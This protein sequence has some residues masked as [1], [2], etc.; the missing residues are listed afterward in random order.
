MK[1]QKFIYL[2]LTFIMVSVFLSSTIF[3][4]TTVITYGTITEHGSNLPWRLYDD[5]TLVVEGGSIN[6]SRDSAIPQAPQGTPFPFTGVRRII[7]TGSVTAGTSLSGLFS[8]F[9]YVTSIDGLEHFDTSNVTDMSRMFQGISNIE[10]LD[11][12]SWDV[13][14]VQYM[15]T[16]FTNARGLIS[17]DLSGWDNRNVNNVGFFWASDL[18][19]LALGEHFSFGNG[20]LPD[21]PNND[22]FVGRW[23]NVGSGTPDNPQGEFVFTSDE[24][25][26]YYDGAIHADT[27]VWQPRSSVEIPTESC[28]SVRIYG[29]ITEFGSNL[30]W[31]LCECGTM[32]VD[33]GYINWHGVWTMRDGPS[34]SGGYVYIDQSP[35]SEYSP[36]IHRIV[37]TGQITA[38]VSLRSL[39]FQLGNVVVIDGLEHFDTSNV[40]D[41]RSVFSGLGR[42][43]SLDG[44]SAWNVGN[45][46]E[47][48]HMFSGMSSL[49]ALDLS[50]WDTGNARSMV[51]MFSMPWGGTTALRE[52]N[53]SGWDTRNVRSMSAMF[54]DTSLLAR[55]DISGWNLENLS[56]TEQ[57]FV[58][59]SFDFDIL[60][61]KLPDTAIRV[62]INGE[63][64]LFDVDP[65]IYDNRTLVPMRAIF[66]ALGFEVEWDN[67]TRM[68]KGTRFGAPRWDLPYDSNGRL[69]VE[70][71]IDSNVA[72]INGEPIELDVPAMLH[73]ERTMIPVRFIAEASG[74]NVEWDDETRTV[75]ISIN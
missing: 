59:S 52:L 2:T 11:L 4:E 69:V 44:I 24:L 9:R 35:W 7:F 26:R 49:V 64:I 6:Q 32:T 8:G 19:Q 73:N 16:M 51:Y 54:R 75:M 38:G 33:S 68:A 12:S 43:T 67:Y 46:S 66:E 39:F 57:M 47:M 13:R 56:H 60:E 42:A 23:Q 70:I 29:T 37:F 74:A 72:Y 17:L 63:R 53:L 71:P 22:E 62:R 28:D 65:I 10:N 21:V 61:G 1:I 45:A 34:G 55:L 58:R 48:G 20:S 27:W 15:H 41:M 50:N 40:T 31:A 30:P 3:A 14:N 25:T 36:H 5:G 18:R